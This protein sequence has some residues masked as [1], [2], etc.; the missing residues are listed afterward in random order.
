[1]LML[2]YFFQKY[3]VIVCF[4]FWHA[5]FFPAVPQVT[6]EKIQ[7]ATM[8]STLFTSSWLCPNSEYGCL[9]VCNLRTSSHRVE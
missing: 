4:F 1:M 6:T 9:E 8:F 5:I 3:F 2:C 7:N